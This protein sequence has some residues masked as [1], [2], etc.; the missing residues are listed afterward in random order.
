MFYRISLNRSPGVIE[1]LGYIRGSR[2][3]KAYSQRHVSYSTALFWLVKVK[4]KSGI[5]REKLLSLA[6][7]IAAN[8]LHPDAKGF[9]TGKWLEEWLE[10]PQ[11]A[12][13]DMKPSELLDTDE[14]GQHVL[15]LLGA[16][17]SGSYQ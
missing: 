6:E 17:E 3:L 13:G 9:D 4:S 10:R 1:L 7:H 16:L 11:P 14:G 15:R 12:L 8:S 5:Y 2:F